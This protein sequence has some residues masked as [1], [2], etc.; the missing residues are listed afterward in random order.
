MNEHVNK[1]ES[2]YKSIRYLVGVENEN[3]SKLRYDGPN[4]NKG[5]D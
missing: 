3:P 2:F 5:V 1:H 4:Q